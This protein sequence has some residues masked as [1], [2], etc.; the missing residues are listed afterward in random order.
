MFNDLKNRFWWKGMK[1]NVYQY[2][3]KYLICQHVKVEH[4]RRKGFLQNL[5]I[6]EWKWEHIIMNFMTHLPL[7]S[8]NNDAIWVVRN[9]LT[10][11]TLYN[12]DF[13]F[14]KMTRLYIHD[15]L[16]L[17]GASEHS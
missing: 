4:R 2:V 14:D 3:S 13:T 12:Q 16:R 5:S 11:S 8:K 6:P 10:K 7:S 17:N 9:L 1:H 15:I